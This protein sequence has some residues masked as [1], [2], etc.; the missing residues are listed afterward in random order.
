MKKGDIINAWISKYALTDGVCARR[1]EF[2]G[3]DMVN[4]LKPDGSRGW[5]YFH[6]GD[7]HL[8]K[9]DADQKAEQTRQRKIASVKKQLARLEALTFTSTDSGSQA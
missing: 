1:V 7:W 8:S 9:A 3:D 2:C 6:K 5:G 4:D